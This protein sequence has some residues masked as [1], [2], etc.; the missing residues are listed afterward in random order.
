MI[1]IG[2]AGRGKQRHEKGN[3]PSHPGPAKEDVQKQDARGVMGVPRGRNDGG[4][5]LEDAEKDQEMHR[6]PLIGS[7]NVTQSI[8]PEFPVS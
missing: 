1:V 8:P 2:A 3:E 4:E 5:E 6:S 7:R